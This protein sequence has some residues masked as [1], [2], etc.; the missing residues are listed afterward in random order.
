[1]KYLRFLCCSF[2]PLLLLT[3]GCLTYMEVKARGKQEKEAERCRNKWSDTVAAAKR[4]ADDFEV[5]FNDPEYLST[6]R[7]PARTALGN[8]FLR[9]NPQNPTREQFI[10]LLDAVKQQPKLAFPLKDIWLSRHVTVTQRVEFAM[11]WDRP[12]DK[13]Q[14]HNVKCNMRELFANLLPYERIG[15]DVFVALQNQV[16]TNGYV[17]AYAAE[18]L[19][20]RAFVRKEASEWQEGLKSRREKEKRARQKEE[21]ERRE[22]AKKAQEARERAVREA[23]LK[24]RAEAE[25]AIRIE[26]EKKEAAERRRQERRESARQEKRT[27]EQREWGMTSLPKRAVFY[28]DLHAEVAQM[29]QPTDIFKRDVLPLFADKNKLELYMEVVRWDTNSIPLG[30]LRAIADWSL[31]QDRLYRGYQFALMVRPEFTPE[32]LR[33]YY[34]KMRS[35][36]R[37]ESGCHGILC[38]SNTPKDLLDQA[39]K[40]PCL[41][42]LRDNYFRQVYYKEDVLKYDFNALQDVFFAFYRD[43]SARKTS[44]DQYCRELDLLLRRYLP[45]ERPE[46]W[47]WRFPPYYD[48]G[49]PPGYRYKKHH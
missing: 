30:T 1:M 46:H 18:G 35:D 44:H 5:V 28:Q 27:M 15:D 22:R 24:A 37:H 45:P 9:D 36:W 29:H 34:P 4:L 3:S 42:R 31:T 41:A 17:Y 43:A 48:C 40:D 21:E 47:T 2:L 39:Y 6:N 14:E 32:I 20:H 8:H 38:N 33:E 10:R 19:R 23:E 13:C 49:Y 11:L 12:Q 26:Q 7:T 25:A 16:P